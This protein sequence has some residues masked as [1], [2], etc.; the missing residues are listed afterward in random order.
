MGFS[1]AIDGPSGAGKS[2]A[3]KGLAR[4]LG[5]VYI[6]TGAMYRTVAYFLMNNEI[7]LDEK[8]EIIEALENIVL[9]IKYIDKNQH[10]FLNGNDVTAEIRSRA[11]S[12]NASRV[13]AV[14]EVRQKLVSIQRKMAEGLNVV[15]DGRDIGTVVLP[16]ADI[17]IYLTASVK[18]RAERRLLELLEKGTSATLEDIKA[19]IEKRDKRDMTREESPLKQAEDAIVIDCGNMSAKEVIEEMLNLVKQAYSNKK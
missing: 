5:F 17:K 7:D 6:D 11:V 12:E 14:R 8:A 16:N 19:D 13:S 9:D 2:T 18:K 3:A 10:I 15:M 1:I 4:E